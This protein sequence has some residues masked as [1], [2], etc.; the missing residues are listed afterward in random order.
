MELA[1]KFL[2]TRRGTVILGVC[3]AV[4]AAIMLLVYLNRYR[5]SLNENN[6]SV[7]VL[8]AKS[9][10]AKG[11]PGNIIGTQRQFQVGT[12]AKRELR[13]GAITDP[14]TLRGLV[15]THDIY[16]GQQLTAED[17]APVAPGSLQTSLTKTYRAISIPFDASH[18]LMGALS[19]GDHVDVY[20]GLSQIAAVGA[21][22]VIKQLMQNV[23]VLGTPGAGAS[24]GNVILR[25][26][27]PQAAA[28]AFAADNGKI[29]LVLRPASGS[30]NVKPGL[31]TMQR[32]L[33][34]V[35][36]R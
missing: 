6:Q 20:V 36:G 16:P 31:I 9:L 35:R 29:W 33:L 28:L 15:A 5:S 17:F 8:V 18:G 11:A 1:E 4:I 27:G 14:S 2:S 3:A 26:K 13:S 21:Q 10:I 19:P 25:A 22:P 32:L 34:G 30:K 23:L 24:S 12:I 7:S